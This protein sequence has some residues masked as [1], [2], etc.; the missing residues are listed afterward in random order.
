MITSYMEMEEH[1]SISMLLAITNQRK[2]IIF[3]AT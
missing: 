3:G 1:K 2:K